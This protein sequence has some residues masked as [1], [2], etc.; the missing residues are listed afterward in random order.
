MSAAAFVGDRSRRPARVLYVQY[1]NPGAYPPVDHSAELLAEA[2]FEVLVLG[3]R[4]ADDP[5]ELSSHPRVRVATLPHE[6][7]GWRQKLH[8]A[9][10]AAWALLWTLRWRP[11]WVYASD[12]PSCPVAL[13]AGGL[14]GVRVL[15]HE[16]DS[17]AVSDAGRVIARTVPDKVIMRARQALARRCELVVLPNEARAATYARTTGRDRVLTVWNTPL[18]REVAAAARPDTSSS[19]LRVLYHGS[20]VPARLP[21]AVIDAIATLPAGVTLD[22][23]GY[24]TI[25]HPGYTD[26]LLARARQLG[27]AERVRL[28][29]ALRRGDLMRLCATCD[30]GLALLPAD[31]A[32]V[33]ERAMVGASNK[34]F[35]YMASGLALLVPALPEWL[36]TYVEPGFGLACD[37]ASVGSLAAA[38]RWCL[39]H[40]AERLAM[41]VRGRQ[42]ILGEWNYERC[43]APVLD[44]VRTPAYA[45]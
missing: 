38:L 16:H 35:D 23:A 34:P 21:L 11:Q 2:G 22:I 39:E 27:I 6:P 29:G 37:P 19:R 4:R 36:G 17:P 28:H 31:S 42:K 30:V 41:G 10:F 33:N 18:R 43:F 44:Q 5:L 32:D 25:G 40:S 26:A 8:Y 24:E 9:R 15:Y 3:T 13:L 45:S 12:P 1:T 14:P 7:P 20:I